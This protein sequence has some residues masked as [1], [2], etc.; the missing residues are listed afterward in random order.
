MTVWEAIA[1]VDDLK[2][3][4]YDTNT[5]IGWLSKLDGQIYVEVISTHG[6]TGGEFQRKLLFRPKRAASGSAS[7][8][9]RPI[10][11]LPAGADRQGER[12]NG[13][14]QSVYH[15]LQQRVPAIS[16]LVQ[17]DA[18]ACCR[19][20]EILILRIGEENNTCLYFLH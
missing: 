9:R 5:K 10:C 6:Q 12:R 19:R 3:N 7:F 18:H 8:R 20:T 1:K 11:L 17:P 4:Q 2:P 16:E 15:A 14:V 13:Q